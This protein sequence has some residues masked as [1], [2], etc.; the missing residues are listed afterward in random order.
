MRSEAMRELKLVTLDPGHFHAALVQKEMYAGVSRRAAV[1]APL[2][3][4]LVAHLGRIVQFN[5][6]QEDPTAWELEV[7]A[8]PHFLEE[9]AG[10]RAGDIAVIAGRNRNKITYIERAVE[11]GYHVLADKPWII[12]SADLARLEKV[13]ERAAAS[14]LVAYDIMT[15]RYE[16][17]SIL[18]RELVR[19]PAVFGELPAGSVSEPAVLLR[20]VH[21]IAKLVAGVPLLRPAWFFDVA[22]Q[23]EALA[24]VGTHLVD[25]VAWTLAPDAELDYRSDIEV[26]EGEGW[27]TELTLEQYRRV[28]GESAFADSLEPYV[29]DGRLHYLCNNRVRYKLRGALV[30]VEALW[31]Y[32]AP[33]GAG[34]THFASYQG[35]RS[36]IE[37][38]QGEPEGYRPELYVIPC[39]AGVEEALARRI[40]ALQ[41]DWPG[42]GLER[43]GQEFRI[44]IPDRYRVG[45]E[46]HFAQVARQFL[47]YVRGEERL[48]AW[49]KAAMPAKYFVTTRGVELR[50]G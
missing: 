12:R 10:E 34:D 32:E 25:L 7:F 36:R 48:P 13:L 24:D 41:R 31:H 16:I 37:V 8:S 27:P 2:G 39:E 33:P 6:R 9:M 40:A 38:R 19:D 11:A 30:M 22:E 15:E 50:A 46:A 23:G 18:Q 3:P 42:T 20:S 29:R 35:T 28:T 43:H 1:F 21:H 26:L 4:D 17:T 44:T 49:E 45:H 5:T 14:G 47:R